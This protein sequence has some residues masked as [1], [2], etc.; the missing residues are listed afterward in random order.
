MKLVL[1]CDY[2]P[3]D[4]VA[5]GIKQVMYT[6]DNKQLVSCSDDK[7]VRLW[8]TSNGSEIR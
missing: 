6:P 7:T 2:E 5:G 4:D 1:I 3:G 8:D